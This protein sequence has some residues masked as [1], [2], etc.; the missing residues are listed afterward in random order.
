MCWKPNLV[1]CKFPRWFWFWRHEGVM[2]SRWGLV[3][4]EAWRSHWWSCSQSSSEDCRLE[5]VMWKS[6][7]LAPWREQ[8]QTC[9]VA[10]Y[11]GHR[12]Y[13]TQGF[14]YE[15]QTFYQLSYLSGPRTFIWKDNGWAKRSWSWS[16]SKV[17]LGFVFS[18]LASNAHYYLWSDIS[19]WQNMVQFVWYECHRCA[20]CRSEKGIWRH[21]LTFWI[22]EARQPI[23]G[24]IS[25]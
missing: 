15:S 3:M 19:D 2:K 4:W 25:C 17:A 1:L 16:W 18:G 24:Q 7:D 14:V 21:T 8:S 22:A 12:W 6:W 20:R 5:G 23:A 11:W 9:F 10:I 13:Q